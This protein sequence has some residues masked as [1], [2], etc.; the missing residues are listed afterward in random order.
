[1]KALWWTYQL[2]VAM[3]VAALVAHQYYDGGQGF[4]YL[5]MF[6]LS[7]YLYWA[8]AL[9]ALVVPVF[10]AVTHL[11]G[12]ILFG[13][14]AGGLLDGVKLGL[15]LGLGMAV[16]KVWP[17]VL[18]GAVGVYAGDGPLIYCIGGVILGIALYGLD[19]ALTY[20][21]NSTGHGHEL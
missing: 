16:A 13:I 12:G 10:W 1:M 21:W 19:W 15:I 2:L 14:A 7:D 18:A 4:P 3:A 9:G 6:P 11:C 17:F 20:F 5:R 8:V